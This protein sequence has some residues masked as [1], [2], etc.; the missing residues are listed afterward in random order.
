MSSQ[1]AST[2][3]SK[4]LSSLPE[5][6]LARVFARKSEL[7]GPLGEWAARHPQLMRAVR[8]PQLSLTLVAA[9]P[10]L[11]V[12]ELMPGACLS[13]W[14]FAVDDLLDEGAL[15]AEQSREV[16]ATLE[17]GPSLLRSGSEPGADKPLLTAL[18][19]IRR[20]LEQLPEG[21][22]PTSL[23]ES[24][25]GSLESSL[26]GMRFEHEWNVARPLPSLSRYFDESLHSVGVL[27]V[28]MCMLAAMRAAEPPSRLPQLL[29]QGR[30]AA[31]KIRLANDLRTYERELS[32]GKLNAIRILQHDI[33]QEEKL[34][35]AEALEEARLTL[36]A[37]LALGMPPQAGA[38]LPERVSSRAKRWLDRLPKDFVEGEGAAV[39]AP[40][41]A[42]NSRPE[43][44][45]T[46]LTAF[47]CDYYAHHDYH[48]PLN[49]TGWNDIDARTP[50]S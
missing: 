39:A 6:V 1:K 29:V 14:L 19:D 35:E 43:H 36:K 25:A 22:F 21:S 10:F 48:H 15:T 50:R 38:E 7:E 12:R 2:P 47:V 46:N 5:E 27:P 49:E 30:R 23:R 20:Q 28:Y 33:L 18:W 4:F 16:W 40:A 13:M 24:L 44:Y 9:A 11:G 17:Q 26:R 8:V 3:R 31:L 42:G 32:E 34:E 37:W 41:S 45:A